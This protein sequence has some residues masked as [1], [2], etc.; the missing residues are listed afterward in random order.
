MNNLDKLYQ[1]RGLNAFEFSRGYAAYLIT[2]LEKLDH[3][4]ISECIRHLEE[5]RQ[6]ANTI[7]IIGNGGSASTASHIGNDFGLAVL[8]KSNKAINKSYRALALTDNIS[9]ISAIGNDSTF[10][11]IFLDQL[12]VHFRKGDKLIAISASGNSPNLVAAAE[13]FKEQGGTVIGWL[14]FDGGKLKNIV[15]VPIVVE[16]PKGEY[17]P[18]EDIHLVINHIIVT[19]MQYHI[20]H[21]DGIV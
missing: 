15:D 14:G 7:F 16:S 3:K 4:N 6:N 8:K 2:L 12:K 13:W 9:V 10:N 18:V 11:N 1:E 17:A 5:A 20:M 19:W 21:E